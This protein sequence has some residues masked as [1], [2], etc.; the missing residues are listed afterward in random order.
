MKTSLYLADVV[1]RNEVDTVSFSGFEITKTSSGTE[2]KTVQTSWNPFKIFTG[3]K[4]RNRLPV[5]VDALQ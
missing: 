5:Q 1:L 2:V 3:W 4:T